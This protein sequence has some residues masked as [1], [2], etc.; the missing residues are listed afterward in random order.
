MTDAILTH[1]A[2]ILVDIQ[3]DFLPGGPL[4]CVA[5]DAILAPVQSLLAARRFA[6]YIATQDWHPPGHISFA[7]SHPGKNPFDTID[8]YNHPQ[9]LW[10]DRC[11]QGTHGAALL[12][13]LDWDRMNAI[14]RKGSDP[15]VDSYSAFRENY[16][17]AGE[18]P[19][20][21]LAGWLKDRQVR[22]VYVCG[23]ARD[24]CVLWTAQDARAAGFNTFVIWD[25]TAPVSSDA[26]EQTRAA[27]QNEGI[28]IV[29]S[30][31]VI[32]GR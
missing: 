10:P 24:F 23:L 15:A 32:A 22:D 17:P 5:A 12:E 26:D 3:P 29:Q 14:I 25:A 8:L 16:D 27:M 21:G 9:V 6:H 2:L 20:T 13:S 4:A 7:S 1:S 30:D 11:V 19:L 31:S 18:R 28:R